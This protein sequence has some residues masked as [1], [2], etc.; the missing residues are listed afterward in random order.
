MGIEAQLPTIL[1]VIVAAAIDSVN[2][3]AIGVLILML[4]V[5]LG[6]GGSIK[7]MVW[8]G[9]LYTGA[10]FTVYLAAGIGLA[11]YFSSIP[12]FV[13]EYLSI[14]V[15]VIIIF[16]GIVEI[17]DYFWYGK[18]FSLSIPKGAADKLH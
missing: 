12:L 5:V 14:A 15:G 8:L 6:S 17:K 7:R 16:L 2:P 13:S 18:G 4:S 9:F 1:A 11:Y 3:C 10:G